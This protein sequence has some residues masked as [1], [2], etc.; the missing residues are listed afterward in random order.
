ME[1]RIITTIQELE[2]IAPE[3]NQLWDQS[4]VSLPTV[5]AEGVAAWVRRFG[6]NNLYI[7]TVWH[8]EQLVAALPLV[9]QRFK[10]IFRGLAMTS[11]GWGISGDLLLSPTFEPRLLCEQIIE[12]IEQAPAEFVVLD[13]I[14]ISEKRWQSLVTALEHS[15]LVVRIAES[16]AI[17]VTDVFQDWESY[18]KSWSS[19]HR[20]S[21]KKAI[22]RLSQ[23]GSVS[24]TCHRKF[25]DPSRLEKLV[26][27]CFKVEH[28]S[29]KGKQG[30]SAIACS[31][32]DYFLEEARIVSSQRRLDLWTLTLDEKV[33][34]F[35]YCYNSKGTVHSNKISF[36]PAFSKYSPGNILRFYQHEYYQQDEQTKLFD[37]MGVTCKNKAK[38][39]TRTYPTARVTAAKGWGAGLV[40]NLG[41]VLRRPGQ[42]DPLPK[43]G[44]SRYADLVGRH[45]TASSVSEELELVEQE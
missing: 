18:Q 3:W 5:R 24:A 32:L 21:V 35:E 36:D 30:T 38:W 6:D 20:H 31:T 41:G 29:W 12:Q 11:N 4:A 19:N 7:P 44:A 15:E 33:I 37:M 2:S 16:H 45:A 26:T 13:E 27:D 23:V 22:K 9:K 42:Q 25:V 10:K 34:A 43:L 39:A 14:A 8:G 1:K 40:L 17:A 28:S